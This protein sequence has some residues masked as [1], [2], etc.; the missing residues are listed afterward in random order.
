M[1]MSAAVLSILRAA[2]R[3]CRSCGE[4]DL[5]LT[6]FQSSVGGLNVVDCVVIGGVEVKERI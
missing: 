2:I 4:R 6:C 3:C 1:D 5:L